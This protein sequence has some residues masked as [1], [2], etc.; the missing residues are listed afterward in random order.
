MKLVSIPH[1]LDR[2]RVI[3]DW[4]L[5]GCG[6]TEDRGVSWMAGVRAREKDGIVAESADTKN[7]RSVL[8]YPDAKVQTSMLF[9]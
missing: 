3:M 9:C 4:S 5:L 8:F 6:Q 1:K 7:G 2:E